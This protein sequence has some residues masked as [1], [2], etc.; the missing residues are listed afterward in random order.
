M[1]IVTLDSEIIHYEVLGRGR[2]LIFLHGWV[3]SWRYWIPTMQAAS[4]SYRAYAID[5]WGFG[6]TAKRAERYPISEQ[7]R[8]LYDF[9]EALGIAKIALV[10]HGLGAIVGLS[11]VLNYPNF[12]DRVML[13]GFPLSNTAIN[14]RLRTFTVM[15][16]ADWLLGRVPAADA[17]RNEAPKTDPQ[18]IRIS[19]D[20]IQDI[21]LMDLLI[22]LTTPC[23][24]VHGQNDPAV[25]VPPLEVLSM[26]P[27][28]THQVVFEASG[29]FP[30]LDEPSKYNRLLFDFLSLPS[31]E[32]PRQLQL[33][34]EWKRRIR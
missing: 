27:D 20:N 5:L 10:G 19:L 12:V 24:F 29:H 4:I 16:L 30:M 25:E 14:S 6:D 18:A 17:A 3:G 34:E 22:H 8:L 26:L 32:S 15:E 11:F 7:V 28:Q 9:M 33:K 2:P 13:T 21:N 23:L 1:S 31:G